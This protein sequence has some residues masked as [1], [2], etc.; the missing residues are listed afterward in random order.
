[1][2]SY[3]RRRLQP[4]SLSEAICYYGTR[5]LVIEGG[6]P[7]NCGAMDFVRLF[8]LLKHSPFL[9]FCPDLVTL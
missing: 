3:A 2:F 8:A 9:Q 6:L 5:L 7:V 4:Q 1:M